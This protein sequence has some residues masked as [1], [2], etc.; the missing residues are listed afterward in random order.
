M[1]NSDQMPAAVDK[2][3]TKRQRR[4]SV[5]L[6]DI[7]GNHTSYEHRRV[8]P[9]WKDSTIKA[10]S[11]SRHFTNFSCNDAQTPDDN[12]SDDNTNKKISDNMD[13]DED[14][15]DNIDAGAIADWNVRD[16]KSKSGATTKRV[17]PNFV[18]N[19]IEDDMLICGGRE[20][21]KNLDEI[22]PDSGTDDS[23]HTLPHLVDSNKNNSSAGAGGD[24]RRI[25]NTS[26][27]MT[28]V[29]DEGPS[30]REE[31]QNWNYSSGT[32]AVNVWL[33][34]LG[35]GRYSPLFEIHEVDDDVLPKLTLEDLKDMGI[36]A[37]GPR[38]KMYCAIQKLNKGF[39]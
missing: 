34:Q 30:D 3:G 28:R 29:S 17:R 16:L 33:N 24:G 20:E 26:R 27:R 4:P 10:A 2:I 31:P 18:S 12:N 35:L 11:K 1:E 8:K 19:A 32:N 5:R 37:V 22:C 36:N 14:R 13:K 6:G 38:R 7:G 21:T 23:E 25:E 39:S 15:D 9:Q